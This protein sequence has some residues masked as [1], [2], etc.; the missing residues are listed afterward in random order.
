MMVVR[1]ETRAQ[2]FRTD[3]T[4]P[5][6]AVRRRPRAGC[7]RPRRNVHV[8][9]R[10]GNVGAY[11]IRPFGL[12]PIP[13]GSHNARLPM[14]DGRVSG[15]AYAICPYISGP[16]RS[17]YAK[18]TIICVGGS[19]HGDN[20]DLL[21]RPLYT[22]SPAPFHRSGAVAVSVQR[23]SRLRRAPFPGR[24]PASSAGSVRGW[25]EPRRG[26]CTRSY[27]E[28]SSRTPRRT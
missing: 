24:S 17:R 22:N 13:A 14:L 15:R 9:C 7:Q 28:R 10:R 23:A 18:S 2:T 1:K 5:V 21:G 3:R 8:R 19:P 20:S 25:R 12:Q 16:T 27:A 11:R 26:A 4:R 6:L